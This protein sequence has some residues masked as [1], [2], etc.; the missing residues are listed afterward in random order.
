MG[1][2]ELISLFL[3]GLLHRDR[4][5]SQHPNIPSATQFPTAFGDSVF[6]WCDIFTSTFKFFPQLLKH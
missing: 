4:I 1:K 6:P 3:P 5:S 2:R